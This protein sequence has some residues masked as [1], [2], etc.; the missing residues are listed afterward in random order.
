M[1]IS[2][3][4]AFVLSLWVV[5]AEN[6]ILTGAGLIIAGIVTVPVTPLG[7]VFSIELTHPIQPVLANGFL[8]M[9]AQIMS[10]IM[11]ISISLVA[12]SSSL[13]ALGTF[14]GLCAIAS[15]AACLMKEELRLNAVCKD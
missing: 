6:E 1:T 5:P 2:T 15:L 10:L 4:I 8:L 14:S 13:G 11:S 7:F 9:C 12:K 3:T